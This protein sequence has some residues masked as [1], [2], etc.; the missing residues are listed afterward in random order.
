MEHPD[1]LAPL[2]EEA[3]RHAVRKNAYWEDAVTETMRRLFRSL[4]RALFEPD[5]TQPSPYEK[6]VAASLH[7]IRPQVFKDLRHRWTVE[8]M[9]VLANMSAARFAAAYRAHFDSGPF[10]DL[11]DVRLRHAETLLMRLPI[12]V[13]DAA[14]LSGFNSASNFHVRFRERMGRSPRKLRHETRKSLIV[15]D[16][17]EWTEMPESAQRVELLYI[18]P[19][20]HWSFDENYPVVDDL[21]KHPPATLVN[22]VATGPGRRSGRALHFDGASYTILPEAA[23]DTR[24]SYTASAWVMCT[25]AGRMTGVSIGNDHHG[26]FYLQYIEEEGGFKFAVTVSERDAQAVAVV[27]DIPVECGTWYHLAGVHDADRHEIRLYV[28]GVLRGSRQFRTPWTVTGVTYFGACQLL[29]TI[30]DY[31][32]GA[33]DDIRIYDEALT[34]AEIRTIYDVDYLGASHD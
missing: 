15:P 22:N 19:A 23:V 26:A 13:Y 34:D 1:F 6:H 16:S 17:E 18:R 25:E 21:R 24:R 20:G 3:R 31:W 7:R 14:R 28:D 12:S 2:L 4:A 9:A 32:H 27:A 5:I 29:D 33:I 8:E 10:D 11:I 30:I